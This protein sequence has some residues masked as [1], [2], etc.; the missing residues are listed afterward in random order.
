M[1][2]PSVTNLQS[3]GIVTSRRNLDTL[4]RTLLGKDLRRSLIPLPLF[5][6][7]FRACPDTFPLPG[8][9]FRRGLGAHYHFWIMS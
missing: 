3:R 5:N 6:K 7:D 2:K 8:N 1:K 9:Y 4:T